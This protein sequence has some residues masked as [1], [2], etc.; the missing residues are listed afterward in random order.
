MVKSLM[1]SPNL[2]KKQHT[3]PKPTNNYTT[4]AERSFLEKLGLV[5]IPRGNARASSLLNAKKTKS[6]MR[7]RRDQIISARNHSNSLLVNLESDPA[8]V[9]DQELIDVSAL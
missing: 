3:S 2:R 7:R 5:D 4:Q 1:M 9:Q 8:L 6:A